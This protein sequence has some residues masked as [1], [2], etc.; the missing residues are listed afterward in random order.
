MVRSSEANGFSRL[1]SIRPSSTNGN[2]TSRAL[3]FPEPF[4]PRRINQPLAKQ[5]SSSR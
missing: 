5:N 2:R 4:G 1:G 3:V